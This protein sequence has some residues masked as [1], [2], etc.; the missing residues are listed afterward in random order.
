MQMQEEEANMVLDNQDIQHDNKI[1]QPSGEPSLTKHLKLVKELPPLYT[2]GA[3]ALLKNDK[4][5]L[6]LR[7]SKI[8]VFDLTNSK[9][10]SAIA[11]EN[12]EILTFTVSPNQHLLALS[13]KNYMIRVF[14][15]PLDDL[16]WETLGSNA[17]LE[18]VKQF[19]TAGQMVLEMTFDPSSKFLAAGTADS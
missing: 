4:Y 11:Y 6:A 7:D 13:N 3:F 9:L 1:Q 17:Q 2:G 5:C 12:E 16:M 10:I 15:L 19:K 14:A 8:C 18:Q